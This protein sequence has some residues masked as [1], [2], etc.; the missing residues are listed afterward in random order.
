MSDRKLLPGKFVWFEHVSKDSKKAQEF[1]RNVLGWN[2]K[3]FP[4]GEATYEM[5]LTGDTWDTMIGG[6][7]PPETDC[8]P[9]HWIATVSVMD[10]DAA[11]NFAAA[12]GGKVLDAP[13]EI[14]SVG[15]RARIADPQGAELGLLT[16]ARGDKADAPATSGGWLWNELHTN[17]PKKAVSFYEKVVG[18]SHR[19]MDMGPGEKYHILSRDGVDRGGVTGHLPAGKQ[20]HW[21]PYVAVDD[22]DAT[23]ARARK[24]GALIPVVPEDIPGI[25]R[26]SVLED[27]T[28]AVLAV[29]KPLPME[30]PP[31]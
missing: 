12:N 5:I 1:Y 9:S 2:A 10:A 7:T 3:P 16:A 8:K 18:F 17:E 20:P 13:S 11:A 27:P 19:S 6:Y 31:Q 29:M 4:M 22:V 15:R 23:I 28:G 21:L 26:F 14:P 24:L 25:G 30:K